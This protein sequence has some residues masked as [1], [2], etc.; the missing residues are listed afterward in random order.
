MIFFT[1]KATINRLIY[2][3]MI[4]S[5]MK[6]FLQS[7]K[8]K[9]GYDFTEYK[10]ASLQRRLSIFL[11]TSE[12]HSLTELLPVLLHD[13]TEFETLVNVL[14]INM[15]EMFR[16][17][18]VFRF[19]RENLIPTLAT[20][21]HINIW[22]AGSSTGQE[23]YSLAILLQEEGI[24]NRSH[25]YGT[26]I[27]TPNI[28]DAKKGIYFENDFREYSANYISSGGHHSL[29]D[30]CHINYGKGIIT[31]SIRKNVSFFKHNLVCDNSFIEAQMIMCSNVFI[32]FN[33]TLQKRVLDLFYN[34]LHH[35][36]FLILG[37]KEK[38]PEFMLGK[39]F[40]KISPK[41]PVYRKING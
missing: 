8:D 20:F 15:T 39:K 4:E 31:E 3:G 40:E 24:Y 12:K 33:E 16:D 17:P 7:V 38:V 27:N 26:D 28:T 41:F 37:I 32:Y 22:S 9:Y 14:T 34:S 13:Q 36:G 1:P 18:E 2:K 19:I 29:F 10:T 35:S 23:A 5:E 6:L 11:S 21:P 30:Y 25:I